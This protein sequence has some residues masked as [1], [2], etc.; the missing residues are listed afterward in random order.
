MT[1][2]I[3]VPLD[4]RGPLIA[5]LTLTRD[6]ST[7]RARDSELGSNSAA[8]EVA[9]EGLAFGFRLHA[10]LPR[11]LVPDER[12]L[13]WFG[14]EAVGAEVYSCVLPWF[15]EIHNSLGV[16]GAVV[17]VAPDR[18]VSLRTYTNQHPRQIRVFGADTGLQDEDRVELY[19]ATL[20][21]P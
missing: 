13:G 9:A 12:P 8:W 14:I 19:A 15:G 11:L 7:F 3:T 17:A 20:S 1:G 10:T 6:N 21:F 16:G 5:T 4:I 18:R 2:T